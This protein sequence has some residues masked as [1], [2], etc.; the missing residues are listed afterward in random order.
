MSFEVCNRLGPK[1][2]WKLRYATW[3]R[4]ERTARIEN[5]KVGGA[6]I[7]FELIRKSNGDEIAVRDN[8]RVEVETMK[9]KMQVGRR[10]PV[11]VT[12][13]KRS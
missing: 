10:D 3:K 4:I 11:E 5:G 2:T 6:D 12:V 7:W 9:V 13:K 8:G 1:M